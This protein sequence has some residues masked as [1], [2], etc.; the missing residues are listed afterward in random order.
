MQDV[1]NRI[2]SWLATNAPNVLSYLLPGATNEEIQQTEVALGI[3]FPEDVKASYRI[4]NGHEYIP[5]IE[6]AAPNFRIWLEQFATDLEAGVYTYAEEYD[7]L[8][9]AEEL[10]YVRPNRLRLEAQMRD[11]LQQMGL[12]D[13]SGY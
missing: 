3:Q 12:E 4:H 5:D 11:Y 8:I 10:R 1:W 9:D 7:R 6:F 2:E 13:S